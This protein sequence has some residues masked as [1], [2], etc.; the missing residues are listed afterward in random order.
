MATLITVRQPYPN[1]VE[2]FLGDGNDGG[3]AYVLCPIPGGRPQFALRPS[4]PMT[5]IVDAPT[6]NTVAEFTRFVTDR[7]W[8]K[9]EA[10]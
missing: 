4:G 1:V 7:F 9:E 2:A 8:T 3:Q 5:S 10:H 6:C